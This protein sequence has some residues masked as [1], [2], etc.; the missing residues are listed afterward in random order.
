MSQFAAVSGMTAS[1]KDHQRVCHLIF[2]RCW[3]NDSTRHLLLKCQH[4]VHCN[5]S[6]GLI[7]ILDLA[8]TATAEPRDF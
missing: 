2:L 7:P 4:F 6:P 1:G 3:S 5:L 8:T